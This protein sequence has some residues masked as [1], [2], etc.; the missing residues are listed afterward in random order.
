[1]IKCYV[2]STSILIVLPIY[3][4]TDKG[5]VHQHCFYGIEKVMKKKPKAKSKL[6]PRINRVSPWVNYKKEI[7]DPEFK[8]AYDENEYKQI[9]AQKEKDKNGSLKY[10][11]VNPEETL[12]NKTHTIDFNNINEKK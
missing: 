1:M 8:F 6:V 2:C 3:I 12:R 5:I 11:K 7:K 4:F 10:H 9:L